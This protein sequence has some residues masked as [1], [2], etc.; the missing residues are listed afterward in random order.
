[1][2]SCAAA[3]T[4]GAIKRCRVP[5]A[6]GRRARHRERVYALRRNPP[7]VAENPWGLSRSFEASCPIRG[8]VLQ[9][10]MCDCEEE[11]DVRIR[12]ARNPKKGWDY[13]AKEADTLLDIHAFDPKGFYLKVRPGDCG[14]FQANLAFENAEQ[15]RKVLKGERVKDGT[16]VETDADVDIE[17]RR[18]GT[19]DEITQGFRHRG[20]PGDLVRQHEAP[21]PEVLGR[22]DL[23]HE[24][25]LQRLRGGDPL[26]G[27]NQLL[28][29]PEPHEPREA[30]GT[31][32]GEA[33]AEGHLRVAE[34]RL[35][36]REPQIAR[37][38]EAVPRPE[39]RSVHRRDE[40][41]IE[42]LE[43]PDEPLSGADG[44]EKL[45]VVHG[46]ELLN[47]PAGAEGPRPGPPADAP[48]KAPAG[49]EG[50][51][52]GARED[53][54]T[55]PPVLPEP[56]HRLLEAT[57]HRHR[58]RVHGGTVERDDRHAALAHHVDRPGVGHRSAEGSSGYNDASANPLI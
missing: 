44:G 2:E 10:V 42:V 15:M 8:K 7:I 1:M 29:L 52:P 11:G 4:Q 28:R 3:I 13:S 9:A 51:R 18:Y 50:P 53:D 24:P 54:R 21:S 36:A 5:A 55:H 19:R 25:D 37:H 58:E 34:R 57:D 32:K 56:S 35:R 30:N 6:H 49:A 22:D 14:V 16:F 39:A 26:G 40:G 17:V 43:V 12:V 41:L 23:V 47:V 27:E 45:C 31:R 38:R 33:Q 20:H 48:P 46:G